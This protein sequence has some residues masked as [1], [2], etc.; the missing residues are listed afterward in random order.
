MYHDTVHSFT[1]TKSVFF[2][3]YGCIVC[4]GLTEDEESNVRAHVLVCV[5]V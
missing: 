3:T 2:M 1:E 4:W 5:S